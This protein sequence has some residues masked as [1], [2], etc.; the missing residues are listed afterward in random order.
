MT[1]KLWVKIFISVFVCLAVLMAVM[2]AVIDPFFH[3]H[4][5]LGV[6]YYTLDNERYQNNGITRNFDYNAL[7][8]G[9][10]MTQNFKASQ[11]QE[12]WDKDFIK[13]CYAGA[14]YKEINDNIELALSTHDV[15]VVVRCL[16]GTYLLEDKDAER[17]D[18][19]TYPEY[20]YDDNIFN[21]VNY[22]LNST[23][24]GGY[25][26][27]MIFNLVTG[28]ESGITSFDEYS[29]W[30]EQATLGATGVLGDRTSYTAPEESVSTLTEEEI[31][32]LTD[33]IK[34]N[35][36]DTAA[37]HPDTQFYYF[38]PPYS[39]AFW[40]GSWEKGTLIKEIECYR[41]AAELILPYENIHLFAFDD[42]TDITC[43]LD[44]YRDVSHYGS[45]INDMILEMMAADENRLTLDNYNEYY[46]EMEQ[47]YENYDFNSLIE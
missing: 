3:Y 25:C 34:Q 30:M 38:F 27:P 1:T 37:A 33:T 10:S 39:A 36:T 20:L 47:F 4:K 41:L 7:I 17:N 44:N 22:L 32:T 23:V 26:L 18:L 14:M 19:G 24:I 11:A 2:V 5:P 42:M 6:F 29:R 15:D 21:D 28:G 35:V 31:K 40:G 13:V 9:T 45:D 12:L 43:N 8:T 46:D 16:D